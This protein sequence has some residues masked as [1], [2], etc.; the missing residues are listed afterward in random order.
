MWF[1]RLLKI[2]PEKLIRDDNKYDKDKIDETSSIDWYAA[3]FKR[4]FNC[5]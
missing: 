3:R 1:Y 5:L 4:G 2:K